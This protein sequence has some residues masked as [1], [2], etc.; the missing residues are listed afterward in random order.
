VRYEETESA[1]VEERKMTDKEIEEI[2]KQLNRTVVQR[3]LN[4]Y[5]QGLDSGAAALRQLSGLQSIVEELKDDLMA[6]LA[7]FSERRE[8]EISSTHGQTF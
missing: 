8:N 7:G 3:W 1:L 6:R 4:K 5:P 2:F